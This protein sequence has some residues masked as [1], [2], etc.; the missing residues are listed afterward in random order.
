ML[1]TGIESMKEHPTGC[2]EICVYYIAT[3]INVPDV[4]VYLVIWKKVKSDINTIH[5]FSLLASLT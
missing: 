5:I 2:G 3:L 1:A 4:W